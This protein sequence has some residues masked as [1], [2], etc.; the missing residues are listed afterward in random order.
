LRCAGMTDVKRLLDL[1]LN[2]NLNLRTSMRVLVCQGMPHQDAF[3]A[4]LCCGE[5]LV[6]VPAWHNP[7]LEVQTRNLQQGMHVTIQPHPHGSWF[8]RC[9]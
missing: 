5:E 1:N 4:C 9:T 8:R 3:A 6:R 7:H 2:L